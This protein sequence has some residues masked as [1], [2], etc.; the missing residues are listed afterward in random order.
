MNLY[1]KKITFFVQ[2]LIDG[3]YPV[4]G[5]D[6]VRVFE[7]LGIDVD[8]P[9]KQTCC[10]QPAFNT[11]YRSDAKR[12]AMHFVQVFE[13]AEVI[14]CPSGS[15]VDMVRNHYPELF[16][17]DSRWYNRAKRVSEKIFEFAEYLVD[18]LK[19]KDVGAVYN[20]KVAYHESCHLSRFLG[21]KDQPRELLSHV[22]GLTLVDLAKADKCCGFGGTF[23]VK[24]PEI[25]AAIAEEKVDNI[26]ASGADTVTGCDISCLMNIDGILKRRNASIKALHIAQIL[27]SE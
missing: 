16:N 23:S 8:C 3:M 19:V 5:H 12:A 1:P 24:Y 27:A 4:V 11:G 26:M 17:D 22:R 14:V 21:V 13:N 20:G 25:S 18:V 15:C 6:F 10:G 7:R 9:S 2:C